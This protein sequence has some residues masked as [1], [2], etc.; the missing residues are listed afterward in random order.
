MDW[1][2]VLSVVTAG[3]AIVALFLSVFQM[4]LSN[5]QQLFDKRINTWQKVNTLLSLYESNREILTEAYR[6]GKAGEMLLASDLD[7]QFLTNSVDWQRMTE[8]VYH[9]LDHDK[10]PYFLG[11]LEELKTISLNCKFLFKNELAQ[12]LSDFVMCYVDVLYGIYQYQILIHEMREYS[13][14][15]QLNEEKILEGN[16]EPPLREALLEKLKKLDD[17]YDLIQKNGYTHRAE[18]A[19]RL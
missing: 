9:P 17:S 16:N 5:K 15:E 3:A 6:N 13:K 1:N 11:K 18:K 10:Q 19:I 14:N 4:C 12:A 2:L 8:A 7:F